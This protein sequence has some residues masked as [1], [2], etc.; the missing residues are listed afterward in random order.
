MKNG[1]N[2]LSTHGRKK[3]LPHTISLVIMRTGPASFL[4]LQCAKCIMYISNIYSHLAVSVNLTL[5]TGAFK[6]RPERRSTKYY[7]NPVYL[8]PEPTRVLH[9]SLHMPL[10]KRFDLL[11]QGLWD[12]TLYKCQPLYQAEAL[13]HDWPVLLSQLASLE[14]P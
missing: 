2:C 3:S 4:F 8:G 9:Q 10:Q 1:D 6:S 14:N 5:S 11:P 13:P 7:P 12:T